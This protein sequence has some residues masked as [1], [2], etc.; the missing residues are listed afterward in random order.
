MMYSLSNHDLFA[1]KIEKETFRPYI[2]CEL[3]IH[4]E[5]NYPEAPKGYIHCGKHNMYSLP[6][7]TCK[8]GEKK[9]GK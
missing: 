2:R 1:E 4:A 7:L 9:D 6:D 3:C 8:S 5:F